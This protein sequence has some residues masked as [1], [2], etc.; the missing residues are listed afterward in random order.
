M[1]HFLLYFHLVFKAFW[2]LEHATYLGT[3][4]LR[5]CHDAVQTISTTLVGTNTTKIF[6]P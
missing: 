4:A 6:D 5:L 3:V 1:L 2:M